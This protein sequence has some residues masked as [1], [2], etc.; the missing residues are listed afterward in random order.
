MVKERASSQKDL[1]A[2]T[3]ALATANGDLKA[4]QGTLD[5]AE[6][7]LKRTRLTAPFAG[8]VVDVP[9]DPFQEI[10]A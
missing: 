6:L 9:I 5:Q 2:A 10:A 3:A 1:D 7:D 8:Q 4:A